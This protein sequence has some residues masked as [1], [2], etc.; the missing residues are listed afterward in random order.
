MIKAQWGPI[1]GPSGRLTCHF[2]KIRS[3]LAR[4]TSASCA[5]FSMACLS[6]GGQSPTSGV[7]RKNTE[8]Y[9]DPP[10]LMALFTKIYCSW[11]SLPR[12]SCHLDPF[13]GILRWWDTSCPWYWIKFELR[14]LRKMSVAKIL[15]RES[16]DGKARPPTTALL[17]P[18]DPKGHMFP[19]MTV[20]LIIIHF[21]RMFP[22]K[23]IQLL[24]DPHINL[25]IDQSV[26]CMARFRCSG[27]E[28]GSARCTIQGLWDVR[29]LLTWSYK[30]WVG[31]GWENYKNYKNLFF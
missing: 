4:S 19:E 14:S 30:H 6:P 24:G 25:H 5:A 1:F 7:Q 8:P 23:N 27:G 12:W 31:F 28:E 13:G 17:D 9:Q 15:D 29:I 3:S 20:P 21:N 2:V 22:K 16:S 18:P 10:R 11:S 26:H